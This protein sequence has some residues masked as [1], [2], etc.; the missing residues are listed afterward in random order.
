MPYSRELM[1]KLDEGML[2][3]IPNFKSNK[4]EI[5]LTLFEIVEIKPE[6]FGLSG[7]SDSSFYP[8][9]MEII[10]QS[11]VDWQEN[12]QSTLIIQVVSVKG[13]Q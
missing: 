5:K 12:D 1:R 13:V 6:H 10:E 4:R 9:Q 2:L 11:E 8:L 7:L 3:A